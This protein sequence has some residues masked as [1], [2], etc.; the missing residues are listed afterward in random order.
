LAGGFEI[1]R[2]NLERFAERFDRL[3]RMSLGDSEPTK[4]IEVDMPLDLHSCTLEFAAELRRLRPFGVGNPEPVF[5][6]TGVRPTGL[7]IVGTNHLRMTAKQNDHSVGC[8]GFNLGEMYEAVRSADVPL[9]VAFSLEENRWQ[10]VCSSQLRIRD[11][12]FGPP[13]FD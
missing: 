1:E 6:A 12:A 11:I 4:S 2:C 10:G 7:R 8:I 3:V 5:Y 13:P 9:S